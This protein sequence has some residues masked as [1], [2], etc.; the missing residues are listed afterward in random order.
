MSALY[1]MESYTAGFVAGLGKHHADLASM[2]AERDECVQR[3]AGVIEMLADL[4]AE[5]DALRALLDEGRR[6]DAIG[7]HPETHPESWRE[8]K[9]D[10]DKRRDAA[11]A[12]KGE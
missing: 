8:L 10:Y 12:A 2:K 9:R 11:L 4:E 1:D 6:L 3:Y 5:R 7:R